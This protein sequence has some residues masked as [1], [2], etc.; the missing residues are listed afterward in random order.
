M[1]N[2]DF[3]INEKNEDTDFDAKAIPYKP[4]TKIDFLKD[5]MS[6]ANADITLDRYIVL[7]VKIDKKTGER[8]LIGIEEK[9]ILDPA[10]YQNWIHNYIEPDIDLNFFLYSF[11]GKKYG[12]FQ[13]RDC[14][15]PPYIM[16]K[17]YNYQ[18]NDQKTEYL[19]EGEAWIRK[20]T[21]Q[22]PMKRADF[23][24]IYEKRWKYQG[25]SGDVKLFFSDTNSDVLTLRTIDEMMLPSKRDYEKITK[26]IDR[27]K[28]QLKKSEK[29]LN[30]FY[31]RFSNIFWW[32]FSFDRKYLKLNLDELVDLQGKILENYSED[33]YA[34]VFGLLANRF[35]ISIENLGEEYIEDAS[36]KL[37]FP[38]IG[39]AVS[40][41][42]SYG[43]NKL[44]LH[45]TLPI[46]KDNLSGAEIQGII[47]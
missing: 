32:I 29:S 25:F 43:Q 47:I 15:N 45:R 22:N 33:D 38:T 14:S 5:V 9:D 18:T 35:N 37:I 7:G 44:H 41:Y 31:N 24:N 27:K 40:N 17:N 19:N 34:L 16:K 39:V 21:K 46:K 11:E 1:T 3:L 28:G 4:E 10:D 2:Y 26:I 23:E 36:I 12:I 30:Y 8:Y 42:T 13:I 20:N 6:M